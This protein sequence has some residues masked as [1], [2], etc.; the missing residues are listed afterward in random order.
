MEPA[1]PPPLRLPGSL[2]DPAGNPVDVSGDSMVV[3]YHWLSLE[4]YEAVAADIVEAASRPEIPGV[5]ILAVQFS[6][7][8]RN[9]AQEAVNSLGVS[10]PVYLAD[11]VLGSVIPRDVLPVA[12]LFSRDA[13]PRIETGFGAVGRL[14]G[15]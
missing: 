14:L 6:P 3:I 13:R 12:V 11:S 2:A 5:R 10:L 1:G 4:G 9:A 8:T 7:R 15:E